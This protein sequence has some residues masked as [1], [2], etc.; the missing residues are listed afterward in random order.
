MLKPK[1]AF[2]ISD[3]K[4]NKHPSKRGYAQT[5]N[6]THAC[7]KYPPSILCQM[8]PLPKYGDVQTVLGTSLS[9][10]N[11]CYVRHQSRSYYTVPFP[12]GR[13]RLPRTGFPHFSDSDQEVASPITHYVHADSQTSGYR[14]AHHH[15]SQVDSHS[16]TV[17]SDSSAVS[18]LASISLCTHH[19][20]E[21][22][23]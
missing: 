16:P 11:R 6:T 17:H 22:V 4:S 10:F 1:P 5:P 23:N 21:L 7:S 3:S 20:V 15:L 14:E 8:L 19:S 13:V 9:N 2:A 18:S 12:V